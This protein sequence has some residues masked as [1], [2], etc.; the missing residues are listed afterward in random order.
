LQDFCRKRLDRCVL[1]R[2][3]A[4]CRPDQEAG[5]QGAEQRE[6]PD[7]RADHVA[8]GAGCE[9]LVQDAL[10]DEADQSRGENG[11]GDGRGEIFRTH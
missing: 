5:D 8:R 7:D 11:D 1:S 9:F 6:K 2:V 4:V 10:Q 3:D